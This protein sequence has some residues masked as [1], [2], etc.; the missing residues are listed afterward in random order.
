M[1][2]PRQGWTWDVRATGIVMTRGNERIRYIERAPGSRRL[3]DLARD[4]APPTWRA[5]DA[6]II[7]RFHT[8]ENEIALLGTEAGTLDGAPGA[9]AIGM[10]CLD[11]WHSLV[12]GIS[13]GGDADAFRN[14]VRELTASDT[15]A[16]GERRRRFVYTPP[17]GWSGLRVPPYHAYWFAPGY[18]KA[19][20]FIVAF[21]AQPRVVTSEELA[22]NL[23]AF[24]TSHAVQSSMLVSTKRGLSGIQI[25]AQV[26]DVAARRTIVVLEDQR[27]QY[28]V[29][30][31][32]PLARAAEHASVLR[33][34]LDTVEPFA[35]RSPVANASP[36]SID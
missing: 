28:P 16:R 18:P 6:M 12:D 7:E 11:D 4:G 27:Y 9:R 13:I 8:C 2:A 1:I 15:H 14:T 19:G 24:D 17:A 35:A 26:L 30:L 22:A 34:L 23:T 25:D 21:P 33:S 31:Q 29:L 20:A 36:W 10:V 5:T 3:A 32:A